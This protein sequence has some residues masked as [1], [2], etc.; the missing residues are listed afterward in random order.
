LPGERNGSYAGEAV[1]ERSLAPQVDVADR[2]LTRRD[3]SESSSSRVL[4]LQ[5]S[6]GNQA[7]ADLLSGSERSTGPM[8]AQTIQ[9]WGET[10][11]GEE[12]DVSFWHMKK[13]KAEAAQIIKDIKDKYGIA[14]DSK[15]TIQGIKDQYTT[16]PDAVKNSLETQR[17]RLIDLRSLQR[18]LAFYAPILGAQRA[19]STRKDDAQEVTSVGKVKQAIDSNKPIGKLDTTTLGEYFRAKKNMGL[20]K[21]SEGYKSDFPD[22]G[23]QLTGTFIHEIAHG[24]LN[25]AQADFIAATD[26][27]WTDRNTASG[28]AGAEAPITN[29]GATNAAEDMCEAAMMYFLKPNRLKDGDGGAA[30]TPGNPCPKRFAFM[31][32]IGKDWV[33]APP[34]TPLI[35]EEAKPP[36]AGGDQLLNPFEDAPAGGEGGAGGKEFDI[37]ELMAGPDTADVKPPTAGSEKPASEPSAVG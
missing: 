29:Y 5:R 8:P 6:A 4:D 2:S 25:Y 7:T 33:P 30:G 16:V 14:L 3:Q 23:D 15:A 35:E 21:A 32:K 11:E 36:G 27:Y 26:G 34:T 31:E 1:K 10:I 22:E 24:L 9:R 17:W 18:A 37:K 19:N 12:V 20:F 28:K 13:E